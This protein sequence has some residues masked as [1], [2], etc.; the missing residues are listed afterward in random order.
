MSYVVAAGV[1]IN[2]HPW[3]SPN[4]TTDVRGQFPELYIRP[5]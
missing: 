4:G 2:F 3:E 1:R 5:V